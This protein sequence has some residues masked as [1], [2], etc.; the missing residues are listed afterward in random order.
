VIVARAGLPT[1]TVERWRAALHAFVPDPARPTTAANAT[2]RPLTPAE[3][4]RVE[5]WAAVLRPRLGGR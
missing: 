5:P 1:A 2:L 3:L 4:E